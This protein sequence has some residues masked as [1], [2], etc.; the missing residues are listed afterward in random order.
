M[1]FIKLTLSLLYMSFNELALNCNEHNIS[2]NELA[3]LLDEALEALSILHTEWYYRRPRDHAT[4]R[5]PRS[6]PRT[7]RFPVAR[8]LPGQ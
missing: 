4:H 1:S 5:Y 2:F 8:R 6:R 3:A 7:G